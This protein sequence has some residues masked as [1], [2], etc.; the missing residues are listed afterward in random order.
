MMHG[1]RSSGMGAYFMKDS[2]YQFKYDREIVLVFF[3]F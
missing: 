1:G 2:P 3:K